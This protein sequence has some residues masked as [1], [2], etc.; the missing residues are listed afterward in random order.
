MGHPVDIERASQMHIEWCVDL[1]KRA[2]L[3]TTHQAAP[4][5]RAVMMELRAALEPH[6]VLAIAN[7]LPALE[8]G[9][10]L[11]GWT[12]DHALRE[13]PDEQTFFERVYERVKSHHSPPRSIISDVFWLLQAKLGPEKANVIREQL[14]S[15]LVG[16]WPQPRE[17]T[18]E[19]ETRASRA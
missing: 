2:G 17:Q 7:V 11:E 6:A 1:A 18:T 14:P 4:Q 5:M 10:F 19:I 9:I 15:A 13:V 12:L 8:R 3:V 16:A